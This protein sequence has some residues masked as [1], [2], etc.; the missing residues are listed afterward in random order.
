MKRNNMEDEVYDFMVKNGID[1]SQN[2][3]PTRAY[4]LPVD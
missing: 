2:A 3:L 1:G 4:F